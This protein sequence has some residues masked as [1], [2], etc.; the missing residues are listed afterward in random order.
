MLRHALPLIPALLFAIPTAAQ[1]APPPLMLEAAM[2]CGV[3]NSL[4][5]V[6]EEGDAEKNR[7]RNAIALTWFSLG[8]DVRDVDEAARQAIFDRVHNEEGEAVVALPAEGDA[9]AAHLLKRL[10]ACDKLKDAHD[11]DYRAMAELLATADAAQFADDAAL[12][13]QGREPPPIPEK[14]LTFPGGWSFQSKYD[15]CTARRSLGRDTELVLGFNNFGD[16]HI[17][18]KS[19]GLPRFDEETEGDMFEPHNRGFRL[20]DTPDGDVVPAFAEGVTAEN[21]PGT[22][23]IVDAA[24]PI[25]FFNGSTNEDD[26][27][28]SYLFG[29]NQRLFWPLLKAGRT[30]SIVIIGKS[31]YR[32]SLTESPELWAEM[33]EC[34]DQY[35]D[36]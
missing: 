10:D 19:K 26:G 7:V 11:P 25:P 12:S 6:L 23:M 29:A 33:Q 13:R 36:G 35:P 28:S 9:R 31:R 32:L 27:V 1:E 3:L 22:A 30:A 4:M 16:G 20:V 15:F 21:Y 14:S 8:S 5:G 2:R 24:F 18:V 34:I 17:V